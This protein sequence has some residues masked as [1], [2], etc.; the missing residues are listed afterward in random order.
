MLRWLLYIILIIACLVPIGYELFIWGLARGFERPDDLRP[1]E[2]KIHEANRISFYLK[3][4]K[5]NLNRMLDSF[6]KVN[7]EYAL[8]DSSTI[9]NYSSCQC[10]CIDDEMEI[11]FDNSP[12]EIYWI[13]TDRYRFHAG[14]EG[15]YF[16]DIGYI[17]IVSTFRNND[18]YCLPTSKLDS[19]EK[20]RIR[21][22]I[23]FEILE[24][25]PIVKDTSKHED[26][27]W[28]TE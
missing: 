2:C 23:N 18:W 1:A 28:L 16:S 5:F 8:A 4:K 21:N 3:D 20:R 24:N 11:Y 10:C 25:L 7:K 6:K 27:K 17:D 13:H 15:Q 22:R 14:F 26:E 9:G 19:A 12:K